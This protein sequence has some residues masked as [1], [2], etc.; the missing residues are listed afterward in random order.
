MNNL[1]RADFARLKKSKVFWL[2]SIA[3]L[4]IS[5][6]NCVDMGRRAL[7]NQSSDPP[8]EYI[9]FNLGPF[10]PIF[11]AAFVSLFLGTEYSEGTMRNKLVI[12]HKRH[13]IYFANFITCGFASVVMC[14]AWHI[15]SLAG[16]PLLGVW[17]FGVATWLLYVLLSILFTLAICAVFCLIS[18]LWMSKAIVSVFA[19]ILSLILIFTGSSLYNRLLEPEETRD[20]VMA[21]DAETGDM[22]IIPSEARPNPEY[23]AEPMR[24]VCK[25]TLN[26]L[27]T[28]QAILM[29]NVT[30]SSQEMLVMPLMQPIASAVIIILLTAGG[31]ILFSRKDVK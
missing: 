30:D 26:S 8:L 24:T 10:I 18:H 12:G 14:L 2:A 4:I 31:I 20:Y 13:A 19:I 9:C 21:V 23:I 6:L 11:V 17:K 5:A 16:L 1:L 7:A 29:A 15:G 27:P 22:Q 28:G 3:V 25:I